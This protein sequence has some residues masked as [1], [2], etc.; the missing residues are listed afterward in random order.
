M[1]F[2]PPG[3][4]AHRAASI[5]TSLSLAGGAE[6]HQH[7]EAARVMAYQALRPTLSP[8]PGTRGL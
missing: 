3:G 6:Q 5:V 1:A 2:T 8:Q 4:S 7:E